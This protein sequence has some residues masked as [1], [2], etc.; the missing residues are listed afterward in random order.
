M[1]ITARQL[2]PFFE[3]EGAF[4]RPDWNAISVL[5]E[6]EIPAHDRAQAWNDAAALWAEALARDLG[7]D[8]R[9]MQSRHFICV[10]DRDARNAQW[11]MRFAEHSESRIRGL[12]RDL[13]WNGTG[14]HMLLVLSEE[15]DYDTYASQFYDDGV[16]ATSIGLQI[17]TG[18]P[19]ILVHFI[20]M[21][22]ALETLAHELSHACVAHLPLPRWLDE[23]IAV[24]LQKIIGDVPPSEGMTD[25]QAVWSMQSGWTPPV[26]WGELAERHHEFWNETN[27]QSF[28]AGT[29]FFV[30]GDTSELSYSLAE[31][32]VHLIAQDYGN[33]LDFLGRAHSGDAGQTAALE[34]LG[35]G[36][37][38]IAGT[39]LGEGEW[40]PVRKELV[41][42]WREAGWEKEK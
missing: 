26:L 9:V 5:I 7:G 36:L 3:H 38:E 1:L 18:Y 13:A 24:S 25:A 23:G 16:Y 17:R 4:T 39:F 8:Y 2:Q 6:K 21:R 30:A 11:M 19:H 15:D 32:L 35:A 10:S 22:E 27:I 29:S 28:W 42:Q 34:C 41:A 14:K 12:L 20:E 40:R 33:W 31:I 37:G